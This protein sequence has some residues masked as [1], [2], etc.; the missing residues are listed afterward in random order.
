MQV[1]SINGVKYI[2]VYSSNDSKGR[3]IKAY[4]K[5]DNVFPANISNRVQKKRRALLSNA[6]I[7]M[8]NIHPGR[9]LMAI[10]GGDKALK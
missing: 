5:I 9:L 7:R 10:R 8:S 1:K 2:H 4:E 3:E 6:K